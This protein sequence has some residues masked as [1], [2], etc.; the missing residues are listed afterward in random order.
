ML[1]Q[2]PTDESFLLQLVAKGD[3][4]AYTQLF[5]YYSP[6]VFD[7]ALLYVKDEQAAREIVQEI[8]LKIWLKRE[9]MSGVK[10]FRDYLFILTRNRVYDG[11]KK[12]LVRLKAMDYHFK[13]LPDSQNDTDHLLLQKE[14]A[15]IVNK[16]VEQL[17]PE[18][19]KVYLA[20]NAGWSN[21]EI[22]NQLNISVNTVKKQISLATNSIRAFVKARIQN[23]IPLTILLLLL[24]KR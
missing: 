9:E 16:A 7:A 12:Q 5:N 13:H 15:D 14:Y 22:S 6:Q 3:T 17:P 1:N 8:F 18:R 23:D 4:A 21:E 24:L 20:K 11:F 19:K 2:M 10:S